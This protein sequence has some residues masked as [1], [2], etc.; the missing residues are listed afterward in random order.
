MSREQRAETRDYS[1][2]TLS[3]YD[4][5]EWWIWVEVTVSREQRAETRDYSRITLSPYDIEEWW[6]WVEVTVSR[7]QRAESRNK[8][9]L[10]NNS[11]S[12]WY[13]GGM[14]NM[15]RGYSVQ[16]AESRNK[17]L[18]PN[19]SESVWYWGGMVNMGEVTG[20]KEQRAETRGYSRIAL[21]LHD[22]EEEWWVTGYGER[23]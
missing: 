14:V 19:N 22:I 20:S 9:L 5:E 7:E 6:I 4:I 3:P 8:R 18:L 2:I 17:R 10:P 16:R 12:V 1:R 23:L 21:S 11:E 13:W 15:G